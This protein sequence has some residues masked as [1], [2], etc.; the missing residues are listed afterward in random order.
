LAGDVPGKPH[1]PIFLYPAMRTL[2]ALPTR[3]ASASDSSMSRMILEALVAAT[4]VIS[5]VVAA[6]W[7]SHVFLG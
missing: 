6:A 1:R 7:A 4:L 3:L 2:N 5:L